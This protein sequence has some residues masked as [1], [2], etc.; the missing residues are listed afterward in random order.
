MFTSQS[1]HGPVCHRWESTLPIKMK[2][3]VACYHALQAFILKLA[4]NFSQV[5]LALSIT[6]HPYPIIPLLCFALS[7]LVPVG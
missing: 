6:L 7:V 2:S 4:F 5:Y 1:Y 3:G